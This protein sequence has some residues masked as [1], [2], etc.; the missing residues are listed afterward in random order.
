LRVIAVIVLTGA[1]SAS[2]AGCGG[3]GNS[4]IPSPR[5]GVEFGFNEDVSVRDY[6]LQAELG[7]PIRRFPVAWGNV[8]PNPGTWNW[9]SYDADYRAMQA[10][11]LSPLVVAVGAPCWAT[12]SQASCQRGLRRPPDPAHDGDWAEYVRRLAAR[13]PSAV[14][15]EIWNEPN[16]VPYFRPRPDPVRYVALL[17][18]GY[19]AV[20]SVNP[21]MPVI[22]AGLF[23]SAQSGSFGMADAQFLAGMYAAGA[24]GSMDGIGAHPYP[25]GVGQTYDVNAMKADVER[26]RSVRDSAG[27]RSTPIW[28][29]EMGVSTASAPGYPAGES[30]Q[31]QEDDLLSMVGAV[32]DDGKIP[33]ALIHRL[34]DT[35][36]NP[37]GGALAL[38]EAGFGVF[39][40]D[41]SPKAAACGLSQ[42][43]HGSQS[44]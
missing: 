14:G 29:T 3:N 34:V 44:C 39:R 42:E 7:M 26:L 43:F 37:A 23:P 28:I 21:A 41:G 17:E 25:F 8:E 4:G 16:I 5:S 6:R 19:G 30:E 20:K 10:D 9:A 11:G 31:G 40:A 32:L 38:V 22:S 13:Y 2:A 18:A 35:P 15:V 1:I 27:D 12:A 24:G 33:V 36:Y